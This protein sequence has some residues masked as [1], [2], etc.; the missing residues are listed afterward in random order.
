ME[1]FRNALEKRDN[2]EMVRI[3]KK[4]IPEYISNN[5]VYQKLDKEKVLIPANTVSHA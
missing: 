3:M 2:M 4:A 5:S 1:A